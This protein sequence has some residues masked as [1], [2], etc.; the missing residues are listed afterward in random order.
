MVD[1]A[2]RFSRLPFYVFGWKHEA[3]N[4]RIMM[5]E[6]VEFSKGKGRVP[7]SLRLEIGSRRMQVYSAVVRFEARFTGLRY[8]KFKV[9]K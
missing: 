7:G 5:M 3:E 8:A 6:R 4:L 1:T 2:R 9:A